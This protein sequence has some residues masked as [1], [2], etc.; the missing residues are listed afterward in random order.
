MDNTNSTNEAA[1]KICAYEYTVK[2]GDS[3][4]LISHR[5]GIPLRDLLAANTNINP[6][7][8][9]VG[10][11]LCVP[12]EEAEEHIPQTGSTGTTSGTSTGT[13]T[14]TTSESTGT[15]TPTTPVVPIT[16]TV[17]TT[18][19][20][21][22][23]PTVPTTPVVPITP[24]TPT[25]PV[26]PITPTVPEVIEEITQ[27]P[28]VEETTPNVVACPN[29]S[30]VMVAQGQTV[31]DLQLAHELNLHT[32][33]SAN[34]AVDLENLVAGQTLCVP[35]TNIPCPLPTSYTMQSG[36]S[37]EAVALKFNLPIAAILRANPCLAPADFVECT[38][39]TLPR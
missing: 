17:P 39:I 4:Y 33:E 5:L 21:P 24:I 34:P 38:C 6:A 26:T 15:T 20:V 10:D 18:P 23:T 9:M 27:T 3:F 19:V 22:I 29:G 37:L 8:L 25:L 14:G 12:T 16:P 32:L 7:R 31:S 2:R 1:S 30:Q 36:E 11:V 28:A 13:T 35:T